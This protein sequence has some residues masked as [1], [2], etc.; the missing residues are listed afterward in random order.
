M[1]SKRGQQSSFGMSFNM[2]F[3]IILIVVFIGVAVV[4]INVFLNFSD[5]ASVGQFYVDLQDEVNAAWRSSTTSKSFKID[6]DKDIEYICFANLSNPIDGPKEAY[7]YIQN[8]MY[9]D[10]NLF[11][12]PPN[13][14]GELDAKKIEHIDLAKITAQSNP[15]CFEN[16]GKLTISKAIRSKFVVIS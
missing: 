1:F 5:Q 9:Y 15:K 3:S 6:L 2:I 7:D 13:A 4:V 11:M 10:F 14:A 8:Y 16:P 12:I